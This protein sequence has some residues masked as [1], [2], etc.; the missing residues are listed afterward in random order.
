[1]LAELHKLRQ[2]N[3]EAVEEKHQQDYGP[4]Q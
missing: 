4:E 3:A 2:K 1:M